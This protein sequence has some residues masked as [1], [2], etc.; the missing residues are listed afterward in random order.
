MHKRH[1]AFDEV[2]SKMDEYMQEYMKRKQERTFIKKNYTGNTIGGSTHGVSIFGG[3]LHS[4]GSMN[5]G[6]SLHGLPLTKSNSRSI[7]LLDIVNR[8][9]SIA[10]NTDHGTRLS[11]VNEHDHTGEVNRNDNHTT[12][13][14]SSA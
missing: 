5:L 12:A 2:D 6:R 7:E 4:R 3:S 11:D 1:K 13:S 14:T 8:D 9:S 10:S